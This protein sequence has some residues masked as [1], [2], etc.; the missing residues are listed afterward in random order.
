MHGG[1]YCMPRRRRRRGHGAAVAAVPARAEARRAPRQVDRD[2]RVRP[3]GARARIIGS[4][5]CS[6]VTVSLTSAAVFSLSGWAWKPLSMWVE[7]PVWWLSGP[8]VATLD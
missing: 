4:L 3:V 7:P 8:I 2:D 5:P 6:L 1:A